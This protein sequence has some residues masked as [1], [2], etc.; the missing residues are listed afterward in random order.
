[1]TPADAGHADPEYTDE[2]LL[3]EWGV[4]SCCDGTL[5]DILE[6]MGV[7]RFPYVHDGG[8]PAYVTDHLLHGGRPSSLRM[9]LDLFMGAS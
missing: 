8:T 1:M 7:Y 6:G 3:M 9:R 2:F 5:Q 4:E